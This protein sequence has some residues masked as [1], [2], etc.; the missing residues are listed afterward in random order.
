[1]KTINKTFMESVGE[2]ADELARIVRHAARRINRMPWP[3]LLALCV[4]LALFVTVLPLALTLFVVLLLVKL[5]AG[6]LGWS[7]Y[8]RRHRPVAPAADTRAE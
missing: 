6:A 7:H 2:A 5:V 3:G 8:Q 4:L 1:M